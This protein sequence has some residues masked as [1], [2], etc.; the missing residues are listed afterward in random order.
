MHFVAF[1][2]LM[3]LW[4]GA[5]HLNTRYL[6]LDQTLGGWVNHAVGSA[7]LMV[8]GTFSLV[9]S[10]GVDLDGTDQGE[11]TWFPIHYV[12]ADMIPALYKRVSMLFWYKFTVKHLI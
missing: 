7:V 6:I 4:R 11:V 10:A 9:G 8:T 12:R 1:F 3:F 2:L 5:W